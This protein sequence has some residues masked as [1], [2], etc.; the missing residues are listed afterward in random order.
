[1]PPYVLQYSGESGHVPENAAVP[2]VPQRHQRD[3]EHV[4]APGTGGRGGR[5]EPDAAAGKRQEGAGDAK[6]EDG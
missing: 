5:N 6:R 1:M 4:H 2:D 3:D